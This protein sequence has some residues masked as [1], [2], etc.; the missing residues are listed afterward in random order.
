MA[1]VLDWLEAIGPV[2]RRSLASLYVASAPD[3]HGGPYFG[4]EAKVAEFGAAFE[5][6]EVKGFECLLV[7]EYED[8]C[9]VR[10][11]TLAR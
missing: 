11:M 10:Q 4:D 9:Q 7:G 6:R 2:Y 1:V 3:D 5:S 8:F